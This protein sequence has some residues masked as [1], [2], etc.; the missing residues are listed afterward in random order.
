MFGKVPGRGDFLSHDLDPIFT[1][2]WHGWLAR[3]LP[4]AR[5]ALQARFDEAY[6]QTPAWRF[7]T[8]PG[9]AG[10]GMT[11]VMIPSVDEVGRYF[12]LTLATEGLMGEPSWYE[13]LENLARTAL[14]EEWALEPWLAELAALSAPASA[15][16]V[17]GVLFWGDGSPFVAPG[18]R[19]FATLPSGRTFLELLLDQEEA[20]AA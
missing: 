14:E 16:L 8:A 10:P 9:I 20:A 2:A 19:R 1:D 18:E 17:S 4:A 15:G 5:A 13:T 12:P 3:E 7:A 6:L 11:G